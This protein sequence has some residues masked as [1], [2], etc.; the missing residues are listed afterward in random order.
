MIEGRCLYRM[1]F[2]VAWCA[3]HMVHVEDICLL[4]IYFCYFNRLRSIPIPSPHHHQSFTLSTFSYGLY[5]Q[6]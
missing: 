6:G 5:F 2:S 4:L 3:L 1:A